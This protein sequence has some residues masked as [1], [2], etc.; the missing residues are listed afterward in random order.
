VIMMDRSLTDKE[1]TPSPSHLQT[2]V[3]CLP[4]FASHTAHTGSMIIMALAIAMAVYD[5]YI[6]HKHTTVQLLLAEQM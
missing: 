2:A 4:G 5:Q 1:C 3:I 6:I